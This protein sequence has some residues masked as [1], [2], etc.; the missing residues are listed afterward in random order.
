MPLTN[1]K[2]QTIAT[3]IGT[4]Y[5]WKV[6]DYAEQIKN[7]ISK[8]HIEKVAIQTK[9][10]ELGWKDALYYLENGQPKL[11]TDEH[12]HISISH[13]TDWMAIYLAKSPVGIDIEFFRP[14]IFEGKHYFENE[15]EAQFNYSAHELQ[16]IWGAKEAFYKQL[17]GAIPDLKNEVTIIEFDHS[18][19]E[20]QLNYLDKNH[21]LK[22]KIIDELFLVYTE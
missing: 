2:A 1:L 15:N 20:L 12:K 3:E 11:K 16:L 22:F 18:K 4:I 9:L 17:E 8:R 5:L 10:D 14:S 19:Q 6:L 13:S 21:R 7:G